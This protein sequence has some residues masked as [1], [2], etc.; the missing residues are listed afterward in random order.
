MKMNTATIIAAVIGISSMLTVDYFIREH[1]AA[2]RTCSDK[3]Y[4]YIYADKNDVAEVKGAFRLW[5]GSANGMSCDVSIWI[6]PA[7]ANRDPQ[8]QFYWSLPQYRIGRQYI[9]EGSYILN[10]DIGIGNYIVEMATSNGT[11]IES[12][13]IV[14]LDRDGIKTVEQIGSFTKNNK[15]LPTPSELQSISRTEKLR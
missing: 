13:Q 4:P 7:E 6:S 11:I 15:L 10:R 1:I 12:F 9:H 14:E 3:A 2:K 8:N 5:L